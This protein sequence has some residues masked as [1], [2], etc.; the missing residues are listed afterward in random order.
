MHHKLKQFISAALF[1]LVL[2]LPTIG[3]ANAIHET[4]SALAM[5]GDTIFVRPVMLVTT[6]IGA[7][8]FLISSP[9]AALGGNIGESFEVLVEGPFETTFV[10]C[11]GC[12]MNGRKASQTVEQEDDSE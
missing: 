7:G 4:P 5:T 8:L 9:F 1:S 3:H 6:I 11:L 10:R 2:A 12:T